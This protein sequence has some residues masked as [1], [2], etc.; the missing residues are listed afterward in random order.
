MGAGMDYD[1]VIVGGGHNGLV[2]AFYLARA[3]LKTVVLERREIVGGCCVTEEFAPG[4]RASSGAYV[5]SMLRDAIWKD[6][7]LVERGVG[8]DPAGPSPN[9]FAH[10]TR[11]ELSDDL[12]ASQEAVRAL[13]PADAEALAKF[14]ADLAALAELVMPLIDTTAP[15]PNLRRLS[16]LPGLLKLG[17]LA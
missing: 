13:S 3:G 6:M 7:R 11:L 14:E 12:A 1:A 15:D 4:Y 8:V 2:A 5:L 10:G 9:L 16:D 17:G